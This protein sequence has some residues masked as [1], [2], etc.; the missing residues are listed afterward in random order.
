MK[1]MISMEIYILENRGANMKRNYYWCKTIRNVWIVKYYTDEEV[2]LFK[3]LKIY[4]DMKL[5]G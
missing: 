1:T 4:C 3:R 5:I 2:Q